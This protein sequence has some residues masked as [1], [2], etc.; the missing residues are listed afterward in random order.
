MKIKTVLRYC[1]NI[2]DAEPFDEEVNK[3]LAEGWGLARREIFNEKELD[4]LYAELVKLDEADMEP[5]KDEPVTW[6]EAAQ[7]LR[8]ECVD[9]AGCDSRCPMHD[10]CQKNL[11]DGPCPSEW[12]DPE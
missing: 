9:A 10:W 5:Q 1:R 2:S 6:Q 3:L 4:T 11:P 8:D 7:V 12:D